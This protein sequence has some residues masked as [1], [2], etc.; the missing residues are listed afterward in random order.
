MGHDASFMGLELAMT[1]GPPGVVEGEETGGEDEEVSRPVQPK[2]GEQRQTGVT[3][4]YDLTENKSV[5]TE[6]INIII[7][8]IIFTQTAK[9]TESK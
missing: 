9:A 4:Q 5:I 1:A 7:I 8:I 2:G 6:E 3:N